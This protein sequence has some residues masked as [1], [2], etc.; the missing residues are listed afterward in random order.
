MIVK[1]VEFKVKS[2]ENSHDKDWNQLQR[3]YFD[4]ENFV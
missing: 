3:V 4:S 2:S 1:K